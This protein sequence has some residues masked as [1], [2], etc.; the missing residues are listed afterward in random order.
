MKIFK[1]VIDSKRRRKENSPNM[2]IFSLA[3]IDTGSEE[4]EE[5]LK[6]RKSSASGATTTTT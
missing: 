2:K 1:G 4:M 6:K 5:V 3:K